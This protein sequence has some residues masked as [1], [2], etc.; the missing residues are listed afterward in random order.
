[1]FDRLTRRDF[2]ARLTAFMGLNSIV[3]ADEQ[4][5]RL[6]ESIHQEV[7]L[8]GTRKRIYEALTDANKFTLVTSFSSVKNAPPAQIIRGVGGAFSLFG[9]HIIGRQVELVAD[10]RIVQAWR[11]VD[12][13]P[14]IYSIARFELKDLGAR[15]LVVFDHAGFPNG[16]GQH[17]ADGWNENYWEPLKKYLA[18]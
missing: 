16:L 17:L 13:E 11:V 12:W 4:V 9:G 7:I 18:S 3:V 8:N 6:S 10:Q 1:M 5:S 2:A 14:G 15:T